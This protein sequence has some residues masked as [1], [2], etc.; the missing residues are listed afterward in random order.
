MG[1][2]RS[3]VNPAGS[4]DEE[5]SDENDEK[6]QGM[7]G[8]LLFLVEDKRCDPDT[9]ILLLEVSIHTSLSLGG[10]IDSD[11]SHQGARDIFELPLW[12]LVEG[13]F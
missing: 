7:V 11:I 12:F 13:V 4:V 3:G 8:S 5:K 1:Q 6:L 2:R 9:D 10:S